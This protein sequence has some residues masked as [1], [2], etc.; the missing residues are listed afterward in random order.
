VAVNQLVY[1]LLALGISLL[2]PFWEEYI[3]Q[4][5]FIITCCPVA[6]V[7]LNFAELVGEGQD[8]AANMLLLGTILA[9]GTMPLMLL[10]I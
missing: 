1:P 5:M 7:V 3:V 8:E 6:S 4:T 2:I 9:I 10:L